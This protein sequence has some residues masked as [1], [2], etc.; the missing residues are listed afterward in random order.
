MATTNYTRETRFFLSVVDT[1]DCIGLDTYNIT[2]G[3]SGLITNGSATAWPDLAE[4]SAL[5]AR[6]RWWSTSPI[7][8]TTRS[9]SKQSIIYDPTPPVLDTS[10]NPTATAPLS[11][12]SI[13]VPLAFENIDGDR[14]SSTGRAKGLP[15][16]AEFWGVVVA[17]STTNLPITSPALNWL[18]VQVPASNSFTLT[19]GL[20]SGLERP[21]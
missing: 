8:W 17:N 2:G 10:A 14:R 9:R 7:S 19:W 1:G 12:S 13:L 15:D 6:N 18:P 5:L 4:L 20:L 16:D 3:D 11:T 21:A